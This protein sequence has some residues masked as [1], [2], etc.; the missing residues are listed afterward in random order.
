[1]LS[2]FP[3]VK[4]A[5]PLRG[6]GA[7]VH[8]TASIAPGTQQE[9]ETALPVLKEFWDGL[10]GDSERPQPEAQTGCCWPCPAFLG[11]LPSIPPVKSS[12]LCFAWGKGGALLPYVSLCCGDSCGLLALEPQEGDIPQPELTGSHSSPTHGVGIYLGSTYTQGSHIL[13]TPN[14]HTGSGPGF[15]AL[16]RYNRK[17]ECQYMGIRLLTC[18]QHLLYNTRPCSKPVYMLTHLC[19]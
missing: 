8:N 7:D 12:L 10:L 5:G 3:S 14:H 15:L 6:P 19:L 2:V 9:L 17:C 18:L 11:S 16:S 13:Q 1:M 4:W